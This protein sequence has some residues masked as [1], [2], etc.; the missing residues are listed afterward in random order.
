[1][2]ILKISHGIY[3]LSQAGTE[4]YTTELAHALIR[5]GIEVTVAI[6]ASAG[7][8]EA[9]SRGNLPPYVV[10][11]ERAPAG[12][13]GN[14][15]RY[16][17]FRGPLWQ[18]ELRL[19][20]ERIR[21]DV[22]HI[23]HAIGFGASLFEW[24]EQFRLPLVITVPDYWL[25][26]PGI[27]RECDGNMSRCARHCCADLRCAKSGYLASLA[28]AA[29]H[30][31]RIMRFVARS[32]PHLAAISNKT[33]LILESEG[34]P[35]ELICLHPWGIDVQA[36]RHS[37]RQNSE[38]PAL[39]RIG[40]LG[41]MRAHKGCHVLAEAFLQSQPIAASLHFYGGGDDAYIQALKQQFSDPGILFHGRFDHGAIREI[42]AG[43]D[44]AV[45]PSI[46]EESYCLVA[47]EALAAQKIVIASNTGGLSDRIV[48]GVNG[49][50]VPPNDAE[51]LSHE[52]S[53]IVPQWQDISKTLDYDL[54]LLDIGDDANNW[55]SVYETAI[56]SRQSRSD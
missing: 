30:R 11:I 50:L 8:S 18:D 7:T 25:L 43:I 6:P 19:L 31:R 41:S 52:I 54:G 14:K 5:K 51:A 1:M 28:Y 55:I 36:L 35:R 9:S 44:I 10:P 32:R 40:Y 23:Q 37:S 42:L 21:P 2:R 34:F 15:L 17:T 29:A 53:R 27:L 16:A 13:F 45:I 56:A 46:W 38:R 4:I 26:C 33:K 49:F 24:L 3:P 20:L 22:I 12:R 39:T 48:H 47:Q